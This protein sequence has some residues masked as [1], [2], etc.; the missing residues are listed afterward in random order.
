MFGRRWFKKTPVTNDR[1]EVIELRMMIGEVIL[2][3]GIDSKYLPIGVDDELSDI[4][5]LAETQETG[6]KSAL[7]LEVLPYL[8]DLLSDNVEMANMLNSLMGTY[9]PNCESC[10][11]CEGG[12]CS[13]SDEYERTGR[14]TL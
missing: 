7:N 12:V 3:S 8:Q 6:W 2:K 10:H 1:Q 9:D 4:R 13:L 14:V 5:R 11:A